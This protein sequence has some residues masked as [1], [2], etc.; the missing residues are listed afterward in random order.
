MAF[1]DIFI[2]GRGGLSRARMQDSSMLPSWVA[3]HSAGFESSCLLTEL[4]I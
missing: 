3:Y 1:R 2:V 4:A